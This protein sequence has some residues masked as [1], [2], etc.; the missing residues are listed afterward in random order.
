MPAIWS[1]TAPLGSVSVR[2]NKSI[3]QNN[4]TYIETYMGNS[5]L[6]TNTNA[7]RDHFWDVSGDLDGRHRFMNSVGFTVGGTPTDPEI[8]ANMDGVFYFKQKSNIESTVQQDV[9]LFYRNVPQI[10]QVLNI[11]AMGVFTGSSS[12]PTQA[13]VLYSHNLALQAAGTPGIVHTATGRYTITFANALPSQNYLVLGLGI[14]DGAAEEDLIMYIRG[15]SD[16]NNVKTTT[17]V[18][19]GFKTSNGSHHDPLQGWFVIFGG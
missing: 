17:S 14:R 5:I 16:I 7:V 6:G 11:R 19:I 8:G 3:L 15:S 10:M 13:Q 12:N 18:K 4:I 1:S 2:A 9:Q